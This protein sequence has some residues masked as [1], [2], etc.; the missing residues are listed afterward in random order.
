MTESAS[1]LPLYDLTA[2]KVHQWA[3]VALVILAFLAGQ[4]VAV[5]ALTLAGLV[6][7]GGRFWWPADIFRQLTWRVLEPAGILA[8]REAH[9]DHQT[10]RIARVMGGG[11]WILA[12]ALLVMHFYLAAWVLAFAIGIMVSLDA[13]AD[14][15]ALCFLLVLVRR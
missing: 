4:P 2:R 1:S 6:M 10:R 12:A 15:C 13:A 3:M 5:I 8:R 14:F 9:E 11:V 7:V